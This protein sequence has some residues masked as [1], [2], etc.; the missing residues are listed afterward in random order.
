[1]RGLMA[2][3]I[4]VA[5]VCG[6]G[7]STPCPPALLCGGNCCTSTQTCVSGACCDTARACLSIPR[8]CASG[9]LCVPNGIGFEACVT[10]CTDSSEC[11]TGCCAL[12]PGVFFGGGGGVPY[13]CE[14]NDGHASH[15]CNGG[16]ACLDTDLCCMR[17]QNGSNICVGQCNGPNDPNCGVAH[18]I[19][20]V[21]PAPGSTCVGN[22]ACGP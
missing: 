5:A 18:C 19:S 4:L 2:V 10:P 9:D 13:V 20:Y 15:C 1:M 11:T 22:M 6:C 3:G 7:C 16:Q 12:F 21:G 14:P 8:C 17:H